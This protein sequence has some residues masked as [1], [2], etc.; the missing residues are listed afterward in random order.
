VSLAVAVMVFALI[1]LVAIF[2]RPK[3]GVHVEI[4]IG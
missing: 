3:K 4:A 2:P 1:P